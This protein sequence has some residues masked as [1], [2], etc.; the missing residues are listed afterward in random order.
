MRSWLAVATSTLK[1]GNTCIVPQRS[2]I[3]L[4]KEVGTLDRISGILAYST[5]WI[6]E[7]AEIFGYRFDKRLGRALDISLI[8]PAITL[9]AS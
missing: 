5:D 4:V 6:E 1:S 9:G 2:P 3:H 8:V 7:E